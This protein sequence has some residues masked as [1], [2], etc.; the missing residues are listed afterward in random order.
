MFPLL[1]NHP[2][3]FTDPRVLDRPPLCNIYFFN[4]YHT[5]ELTLWLFLEETDRF[6][7][8]IT[9]FACHICHYDVVA[10]LAAP[11]VSSDE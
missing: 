4:W 1:R 3:L 10:E 8:A 5:E 9:C 6:Q 2:E 7:I 11:S